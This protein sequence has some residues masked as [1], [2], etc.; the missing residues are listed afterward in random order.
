MIFHCNNGLL[1]IVLKHT[2][3]SQIEKEEHCGNAIAT[4]A[5]KV[6]AVLTGMFVT[7]QKPRKLQ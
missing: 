6:A 7:V 3:C 1:Y 5:G 4:T 2:Q